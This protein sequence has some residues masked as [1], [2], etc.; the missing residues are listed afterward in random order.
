MSEKIQFNKEIALDFHRRAFVEKDP[1]SA[2]STHVS[3]VYTQHNPQVA[4]GPEGFVSFVEGFHQHFPDFKIEIKRTIAEGDLVAIHFCAYLDNEDRGT[5]GVDIFRI[6]R[7]K[8]V[9]HWD[10][11]QPIPEQAANSNGMF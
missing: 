10:I 9:E 7:G 3:S 5:A 11:L 4:D 1:A 8:V 2:I 6:E